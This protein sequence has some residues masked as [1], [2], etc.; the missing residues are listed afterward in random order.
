MISKGKAK[1][2]AEKK[3][4][5]Q[6]VDFAQSSPWLRAVYCMHC[7]NCEQFQID[8]LLGAKAK[9]KVNFETVK[10][11]EFVIM[12]IPIELHDIT[13]NHPLNRTLRPPAFRKVF[14]HELSLW[15][16]MLAEMENQGYELPFSKE[17]IDA[18]VIP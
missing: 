14:G 3:W 5:E 6:V 12:P 9:R 7:K 1:T 13:S 17:L 18:V 2:T 4:L 8:H 15:N 10:V 11:G 16:Q